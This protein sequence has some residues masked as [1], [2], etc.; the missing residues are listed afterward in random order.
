MA[1]N[2]NPMN[3]ELTVFLQ[4]YV[5]DRTS[6]LP[7]FAQ[8]LR[9]LFGDS[10]TWTCAV[11]SGEGIKKLTSKKSIADCLSKVRESFPQ[12][13]NQ[14]EITGKNWNWPHGRPALSATILFE[15][16][17]LNKDWAS[18]GE[19]QPSDHA[20]PTLR[21]LWSVESHE[22]Y[23]L[24]NK[25]KRDPVFISI[26]VKYPTDSKVST[27]KTVLTEFEGFIQA[28]GSAYEKGYIGFIDPRELMPAK[29]IIGGQPKKS[30][31]MD[32]KFDMPHMIT[33]GPQSVM[34]QFHDDIV[35]QY[36]K[37]DLLSEDIG[38]C[39]VVAFKDRGE[40]EEIDLPKWHD[41]H[42]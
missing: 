12:G 5:Y 17:L 3:K 32:L 40:L 4:A 21:K 16:S 34:G 9:A 30:V 29:T 28:I 19:I 31:R 10:G 13:I 35:A 25:L 39:K 6:I 42:P 18:V 36:P 15:P 37:I 41:L 8:S 20:R 2:I 22:G 23:V 26:V 1:T 24:G 38:S 27:R 7:F 11:L 33:L 14:L